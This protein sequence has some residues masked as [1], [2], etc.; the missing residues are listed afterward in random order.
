MGQQRIHKLW[1]CHY[2][3]QTFLNHPSE[4][5][6]S[7][8]R[9]CE[10]EIRMGERIIRSYWECGL[11]PESVDSMWTP[12]IHILSCFS[13]MVE[14][15]FTCWELWLLKTDSW[16]TDCTPWWHVVRHGVNGLCDRK[17]LWH[18]MKT[19]MFIIQKCFF[20]LEVKL[21]ND[22]QVFCPCRWKEA[23]T[24][25]VPS[26]VK[27]TRRRNKETAN[28]ERAPMTRN[29]L[30]SHQLPY[31]PLLGTAFLFW[32]KQHQKNNNTKRTASSSLLITTHH[33][34]SPCHPPTACR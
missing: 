20:H 31:A 22:L 8:V 10:H 33:I 30:Y 1:L 17:E 13:F 12:W 16:E 9:S 11:F 3:C 21:C 25:I 5:I 24:N 23:R 7:H 4:V 14:I 19:P 26:W 2:V 28:T 32:K 27:F 29:A 34:S 6:F 15:P 18:Q